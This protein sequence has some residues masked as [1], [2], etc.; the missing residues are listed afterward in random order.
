M[1]S[2]GGSVEQGT[3]SPASDN[4]IRHHDA[5]SAPSAKCCIRSDQRASLHTHKVLH[6]V[7]YVI[8]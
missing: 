5:A 1:C 6:K 2:E 3:K 4:L 8:F 7:I